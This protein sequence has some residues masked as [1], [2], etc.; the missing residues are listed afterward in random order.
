MLVYRLFL[1]FLF[2][3]KRFPVKK[4]A[5]I[6]PKFTHSVVLQIFCNGFLTGIPGTFRYVSTWWLGNIYFENEKLYI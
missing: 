4:L 5:Q 3:N 6:S 1:T 2:V